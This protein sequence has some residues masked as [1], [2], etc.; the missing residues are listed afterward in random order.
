MSHLIKR[1]R[2][3][4]QHLVFGAKGVLSREAALSYGAIAALVFVGL[5]GVWCLRLQSEVERARTELSVLSKGISA[6]A[7]VASDDRIQLGA[8]KASHLLSLLHQSAAASDL[9]LDEVNLSL[10]DSGN[11]PFIRY[12]AAFGVTARYASLRHFTAFALSRSKD[13]TLDAVSCTRADI[14]IADIQCELEFSDIY[15]RDANG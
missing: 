8:F 7:P 13:I 6:R 5:T 11:Q 12:K 3:F 1:L 14:G 2:P 4:V 9:H 10:D 15:R